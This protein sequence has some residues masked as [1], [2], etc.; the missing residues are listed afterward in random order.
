MVV[1][2]TSEQINQSQTQQIQVANPNALLMAAPDNS[3]LT[4]QNPA[5]SLLTLDNPGSAILTIDNTDNSVLAIDTAQSDASITHYVCPICGSRFE[6]FSS[7]TDH[8]SLNHAENVEML[9]TE[10][11]E[12]VQHQQMYLLLN[13]E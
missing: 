12:I 10:N 1:M 6:H 13:D 3:I 5:H 11:S 2:A 7:L 8:Y 9:N 4:L